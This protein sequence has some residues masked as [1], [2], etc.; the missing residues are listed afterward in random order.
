MCIACIP[1]FVL[2]LAVCLSVA[3]GKDSKPGDISGLLVIQTA[4]ATKF[5]AHAPGQT[6]AP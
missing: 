5:Q 6:T 2:L 3:A 1:R 4:T